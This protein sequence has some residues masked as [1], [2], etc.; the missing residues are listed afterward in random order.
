MCM[1]LECA[2]WWAREGV[3]WSWHDV[4]FTSTCNA[5][6]CSAVQLLCSAET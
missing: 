5:V 1:C 3:G 6:L 2:R 4:R